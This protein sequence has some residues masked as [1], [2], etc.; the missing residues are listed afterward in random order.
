[1]DLA[2]LDQ[3]NLEKLESRGPLKI[4]EDDNGVKT[5]K[6]Y[7]LNPKHNIVLGDVPVSSN[8]T[9]CHC[10]HAT[11]HLPYPPYPIQSLRGLRIPADALGGEDKQNLV[12]CNSEVESA[13]VQVL[14]YDFENDNEL[15]LD[16][17]PWEPVLEWDE[18]DK[19]NY[20]NLHVFS[21]PERTPTEDHLRH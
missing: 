19:E 3:A 14:T 20:V 17:H 15:K 16:D 7:K 13:T 8:A 18:E 5:I 1:F 11:L 10:V 6:G 4:E 12:K 2:D 9:E 21:E